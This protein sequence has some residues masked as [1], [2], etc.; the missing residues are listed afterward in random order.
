M[1]PLIIGHTFT[2]NSNY[3]LKTGLFPNL[4]SLRI[5]SEN[6]EFGLLGQ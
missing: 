5:L 2:I 4:A 3:R 1:T 6:E